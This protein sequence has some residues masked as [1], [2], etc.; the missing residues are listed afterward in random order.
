VSQALDLGLVDPKEL[1]KRTMPIQETGTSPAMNT[2]VCR[3]TGWQE[4]DLVLMAGARFAKEKEE[5]TRR[6]E[7]R[8]IDEDAA[9]RSCD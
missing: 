5:Q 7:A 2:S 8:Q 3:D 9:L 1:W 4:T 6:V